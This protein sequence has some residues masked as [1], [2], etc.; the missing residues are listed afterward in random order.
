MTS[1]GNGDVEITSLREAYGYMVSVIVVDDSVSQCDLTPSPIPV[2]E[3]VC[4]SGYTSSSK[5]ANC[6]K[7][8][9]GSLK[10]SDVVR[11]CKNQKG[12]LARP[13]SNNEN[14]FASGK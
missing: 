14:Y 9:S 3:T 11:T 7:V 13:K 12:M 2:M 5:V 10:F 6:Y 1:Q 4:P 8:S